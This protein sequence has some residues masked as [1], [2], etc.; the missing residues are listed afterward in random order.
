MCGC[1]NEC[2]SSI[3]SR[4]NHIASLVA[5]DAAMYSASLVEREL[6]LQPPRYDATAIGTRSR[7]PT[8]N[9]LDSVLRV[10]IALDFYQIDQSESQL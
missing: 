2:I 5:S 3:V 10:S 8:S 1:I 9:Y 7:N 6:K 4:C